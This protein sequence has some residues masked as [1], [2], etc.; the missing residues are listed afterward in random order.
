[1]RCAPTREISANSCNVCMW[2]NRAEYPREIYCAAFV[3]GAAGF[4]MARRSLSLIPAAQ[5]AWFICSTAPAADVPWADI[6]TRLTSALCK[7]IQPIIL[8]S[9]RRE[10]R[11]GGGR[12]RMILPVLPLAPRHF[13]T[14]KLYKPSN[15]AEGGREKGPKKKYLASQA[16]PP[17]PLPAPRLRSLPP[18]PPPPIFNQENT[19]RGHDQI[20]TGKGWEEQ[21]AAAI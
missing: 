16:V 21:L 14:C 3:G 9:L 7:N 19:C 20:C 17:R 15:A 4:C 6:G 12:E 10:E 1:M 8:S 18:P 11:R 13:P 5:R 2:Y